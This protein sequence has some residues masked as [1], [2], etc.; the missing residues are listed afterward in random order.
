MLGEDPVPESLESLGRLAEPT[1]AQRHREETS[2]GSY[3]VMR[4]D[5]LESSRRVEG[6]KSLGAGWELGSL[7]A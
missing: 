7:S 2:L 3:S 5:M 6:F 1:L 4:W